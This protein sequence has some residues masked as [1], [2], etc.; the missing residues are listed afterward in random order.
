MAWPALR[1]ELDLLAGPALADGQPSWT[2]HDPVRQLFFRI[3]WPSFEV[4]SRWHLADPVAIAREIAAQTTLQMDAQDVLGVLSFMQQHQLLQPQGAQ[5]AAQMA[6]QL[7]NMQGSWWRWLLHHYLFFRV[8]L[9]RPDAWLGR[10]QGLASLFYT[11]SFALLTL[12]ALLWGGGQIVRQWEVF[13]A[14]LV[15]T[16]SWEG[17]LWYGVALVVVKLLHELGHAFTAKRYGCRVPTMGVAFLVM[18]PMAYTDTNETWRLTDRVQRLKVASAGILTE[19][20][21]AAWA[22]LAWA[23]L[24]PGPA[25]SVAFV[26]A[27]TSW[28]TTLAINASPFMRFDGYFIL[29]D[30]LDMPNLHARSFALARWHLRERLFGLGE[31]PPEHWSPTRARGLILFAWATWIYRLVVFLGIAVLVYH[32]F[33]KLLGVF[34][35]VVE[36]LWFIVFPV[37]QEL[38]EWARR[39]PAIRRRR[40]SLGSAVLVLA[41]LG[42]TFAPW[43]GWIQ[44]SALLMPAQAWPVHAPSGARIKALPVQEGQPVQAGQAL[45]VLEV[46]DLESRQASLQARLE[47]QRWLA[48]TAAFGDETRQ[49]LL[50]NQDMVQTLQSELRSLQAERQQFVP[51]APFAGVLRDLDPDLQVGQWVRPRELLGLLV[52]E[53]APLRVETWLDED[54]L[55]R[56][57]VGDA[58]TLVP[59]GAWGEVLRLRVRSID[60]DASRVLPRPELATHNGGHVLVREK[61][62]QLVPERAVYRVVLEPEDPG[63]MP[64][65]LAGRTWRGHL[66][67]HSQWEAP[68]LRYLRQASAVLLRELD[69]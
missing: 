63:A 20:T 28:L 35:F 53:G 29:S 66:T 61:N 60:R 65:S 11:R 6:Q 18:W 44:A 64:A 34:L 54:A 49:R 23:L 42:S 2:L 67:V 32:F 39:W 3:D 38:R 13:S 46:P 37:R 21:V 9:W 12:A 56:L 59:D 8:P 69:F 52:P 57:R 62:R 26:L 41:L 4:L 55:Q 43:P 19:L 1:E 58:A 51:L 48:A 17:L 33:F 14:Q 16:I 27:T 25:R 31:A 68:A 10:W 47:Q 22:S 15:D 7:Q 50:V 30:A 45:M 5:A 24:T 36:I 40:R